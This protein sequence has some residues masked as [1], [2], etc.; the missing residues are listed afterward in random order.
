MAASL[1]AANAVPREGREIRWVGKEIKADVV[2]AQLLSL[3]AAASDEEGY[4]LARASVMNLIVYATDRG[5]IETAV[6]TVDQLALRHPSRAIVIAD[7]PGKQFS[8]NAEV[9][10]H[11]H[12]LASHGLVYERVI[13]RPTGADATGLHTLVIPLLIPHLQSFLWWLGRPD[14]QDPALRSLASI[15]DRLILDSSQGSAAHLRDI[16]EQLATPASAP[17]EAGTFGR[18]VIGDMTWTRLDPFREGLARIFDEAGRAAYLDELD[19]VDITG[20]RGLTQEVSP[21]E[22]LLAGWLASRLGC[23]SPTPTPGGVSMRLEGTGRNV[24]FN[25]EGVR[26]YR[27][28]HG[29]TAPM[30]SVFLV[31][32]RGRKKLAVE[33]RWHEDEGRLTIKETGNHLARRAV[34]MARQHET[35]VLSMQLARLGRDRVYEDAMASAAR[36][37]A[38]MTA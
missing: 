28:V 18:L 5:Q 22:V 38:A 16:S 17:V 8:L 34:A 15:C 30:E 7:R 10:I 6:A 19:R 26:G 23:T 9:T 37:Q 24:L 2:A 29:E 35:E 14:P 12:P 3:R 27:P 31:A 4:P 20:R 32:E 33:L 36:I 11:S 1:E 13:M 21:A 25:F